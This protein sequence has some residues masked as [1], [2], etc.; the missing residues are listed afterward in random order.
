MGKVKEEP[1]KTCEQV[2]ICQVYFKKRHADYDGDRDACEDY[3]SESMYNLKRICERMNAYLFL[4]EVSFPSR[5]YH[6]FW[7]DP[8]KHKISEMAWITR[9]NKVRDFWDHYMIEGSM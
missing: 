6:F 1:C 2:A 4:D 8:M 5:N 7:W 3:N 9:I